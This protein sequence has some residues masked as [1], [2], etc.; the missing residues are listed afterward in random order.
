MSSG[1]LKSVPRV[2]QGCS[3][4]FK[5]CSK[6]AFKDVLWVFLGCFKSV[7]RVNQGLSQ[8]C[9]NGV[10]RVFKGCLKGVLKMF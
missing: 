3:E 5:M 10:P 9:L 1:Y 8:G 7:S 2:F 4:V 6:G